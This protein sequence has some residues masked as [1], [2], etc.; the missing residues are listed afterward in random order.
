LCA[1]R[2]PA[3]ATLIEPAGAVRRFGKYTDP[4]CRFFLSGG[5]DCP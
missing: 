5:A 1:A 3:P 2:S 4:T